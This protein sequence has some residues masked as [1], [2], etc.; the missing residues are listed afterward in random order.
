MEILHENGRTFLKGIMTEAN[1]GSNS[2]GRDFSFRGR[3]RNGR[4]YPYSVLEK[5]VLKLKEEV[6]KDGVLSYLGHPAHMDLVYEDACSRIVELDWIAESGRA[7][8]KLEILEDT[9]AGKE[10]LKG[11]SE[12]KNYG[13][14][15][16]GSGSLDENK[17]VKDDLYLRT[18]D[19]IK[20]YDGSIQ[21]CQSCD[22]ALTESIQ[23]DYED[24]LIQEEKPCGCI[25]AT[26][27]NEDK[28]IAENYFMQSLKSVCN[29]YLK[30]GK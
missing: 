14:S 10:V 8:C 5:A 2:E 15:T 3:N 24:F 21:S 26:L 13:I 18:S 6:Q 23:S 19:I 11:I 9:K 12:G 25:Y 29:K 1:F 7:H 27:N 28:V 17:T 4:Y 30:E 22:L 16:R 20:Q